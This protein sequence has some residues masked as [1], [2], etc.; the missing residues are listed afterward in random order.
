MSTIIRSSGSGK[1]AGIILFI[2]VL[3]FLILAF[4]GIAFASANSSRSLKGITLNGTVDLG[5]KTEAQIREE[6]NDYQELLNT[7]NYII[8]YK[9]NTINSVH[10]EDLEVKPSGDIVSMALNYGKDGNI[11]DKGFMALKSF[12]GRTSI[13]APDFKAL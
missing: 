1:K 7:R 5:D 8:H 11:F 3:I 4:F 2:L 10:G 9:N 12:F 13:V 6:L